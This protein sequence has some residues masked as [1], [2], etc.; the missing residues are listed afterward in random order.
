M[1]N[2]LAALAACTDLLGSP[3]GHREAA[4]EDSQLPNLGQLQ[5]ASCRSIPG[6]LWPHA[7]GGISLCLLLK[8]IPQPCQARVLPGARSLS[9]IACP[10][11]GR[12]PQFSTVS[13]CPAQ[14]GLCRTLQ[15]GMGSATGEAPALPAKSP[16]TPTGLKHVT[17]LMAFPNHAEFQSTPSL[18]TANHFNFPNL[19]DEDQAQD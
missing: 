9:G 19:C 17:G 4:V 8:R 11:G 5:G 15:L 2:P 13:S 10:P 6:R 1:H 12:S 18:H 14:G 16:G 7:W 3:S